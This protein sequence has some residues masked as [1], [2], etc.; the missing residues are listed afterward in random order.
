M[1]I[2]NHPAMTA[3]RVLRENAPKQS[4]ADRKACQVTADLL[5]AVLRDPD[6]FRELLAF[7][8]MVGSQV[9]L[10]QAMVETR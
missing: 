10:R 8:Q 7:V 1:S 4:H 9:R 2:D 3:A 5:E 6:S